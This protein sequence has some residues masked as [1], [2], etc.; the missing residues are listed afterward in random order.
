MNPAERGMLG[1][2]VSTLCRLFKDLCAEIGC[3]VD[4]KRLHGAGG[5]FAGERYPTVHDINDKLLLQY[6]MS[7]RC[8]RDGRDGA[9]LV[10]VLEAKGGPGSVGKATAMLS[11]TWNYER[12]RICS[13]SWAVARRR[14]RCTTR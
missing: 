7:T 1:I 6:T 14:W 3:P 11:Y 10:D 5:P 8:T 9:A 2:S 13:S 4:E 12:R